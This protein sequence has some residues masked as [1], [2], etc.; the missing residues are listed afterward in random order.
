MACEQGTLVHGDH[1]FEEV[2]FPIIQRNCAQSATGPCHIADDEGR[3]QGNIDLTSYEAITRRPDLLRRFGSYPFSVFLMKATADPPAT[4]T[5]VNVGNGEHLPLFVRHAGGALFSVN[6]ND[7]FVLDRWLR[8]GATRNGEPPPAPNFDLSYCPPEIRQDL[9][10]EPTLN[11]IDTASPSYQQ[12]VNEVWPVLRESCVG[13]VCHGARDTNQ[14]PTIEL[15]FT[16]GDDER[17]MR[18]NYLMARTYSGAGGHGQ[19]TQKALAGA[20]YHTGDTVFPSV[21]DPRY[22]AIRDWSAVDAPFP[23]QTYEGSAFFEANVQP[24]LIARGCYLEGCHSLSNFNFYKPLAGTDGNYGTRVSLHNYLQARFM[25]GLE[26]QNPLQGRLIKKN[27][28]PDAGG[29]LHR[30]GPLLAPIGR[31]DLELDLVRADPQ[32]RWRD[33]VSAGCII[34]TW[35]RLEREIAVEAGQLSAQPGAVGVFVRRPA[36]PDRLIDF[37]TYRPGADLLRLNLALD[38]D[39]KVVGPAAE[40]TSLLGGCG[41]D[42]AAADVRRPDI[43]GDGTEVV[44]AMRTAASEGLDIW[45]VG[46]DGSGCQRL[47]LDR[48]QDASGTSIHHFDPVFAPGGVYLFASTRGN[49]DLA[50]PIRRQPSRTPKFFLPNSNIWVFAP[51][52]RPQQLSY[53]SGAEFAPRLL[54]SREVIYAVEKAAPDFYQISTRAIRLDDGGGYRPQLGQRPTMGFGQVTEVRELIDFTTAFIG[55]DPGTYFAGGQL[56][57]Q[58]LSL[59]LEDLTYRDDVFLHAVRVLDGDAAFQ[60][61]V[62]GDGVYRSPTPLP[63]GRILVAYSPGSVDLGNP[64]SAVDY[65]LSIVDPTGREPRR[66]LYDTPGQ[67]DIEPVVAYRRVWVPQPNRIHH[68]EPTRG[69]YV[70][71][72]VPL[73]AAMLNDNSRRGS[74]PNDEVV[75]VRVLEQFPA[76]AE[77]RSADQVADEVFGPERVFV[78]RRVVGEAPLLADGSLRVMV[79]ASTPLILEL[80]NAAGEVIDRQREEEQLGPGETQPRMIQPAQFNGICG[81]CHNAIDGS[82]VGISIG[83][84]VLTAASTSSI[85]SQTTALDLYSEP[86]TRPLAPVNGP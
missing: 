19:L 4:T 78:R 18:F 47:G 14:V 51:G 62:A 43:N 12:F 15:Y 59:G 69:E 57:V 82:E 83:P 68:G 80:L 24:L 60:P 20:S 28:V 52:G 84:D 67:F 25:L 22:R 36:N 63:D 44:F 21:E 32:R 26:S 8:N 6:S 58:D 70:F 81:G 40:P 66:V 71:H 37:D 33:E 65:G 9:F 49:E 74:A 27:L 73:F 39:G 3:A 61:G 46:I 48:G 56:A 77:I 34:A 42:V 55:S 10:A 13:R 75:A 7:F 30:G 11:A 54:H 72:S 1:Y 45:T 76:P 86:E 64:A 5:P 53:L 17:Q 41:I 29:M 50:D 23:L 38:S 31:C 35:H 16:C 2:V 85:A 79:P